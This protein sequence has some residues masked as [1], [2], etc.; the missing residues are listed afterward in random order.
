MY[1]LK[2]GILE[3]FIT[4]LAPSA[5]RGEGGEEEKP[6]TKPGD[7]PTDLHLTPIQSRI[8]SPYGEGRGR[9]VFVLRYR[10]GIQLY[11]QKVDTAVA[12]YIDKSPG[13][14]PTGCLHSKVSLSAYCS[15]GPT[16]LQSLVV[17]FPGGTSM[18]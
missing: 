6:R 15:Q 16:K 12:R 2:G 10:R 9:C 18:D 3:T 7:P 8:G 14:D 4:G 17:W 5:T 13:T 1:L 11:R